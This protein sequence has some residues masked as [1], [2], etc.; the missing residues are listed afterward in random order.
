MSHIDGRRQRRLS[1]SKE[2]Q[3]RLGCTM[4]T[5]HGAKQG[6]R[7]TR[8]RLNRPVQAMRN[9]HCNGS[10][11]CECP[12]CDDD[13]LHTDYPHFPTHDG[14]T[15]GGYSPLGVACRRLRRQGEAHR[16]HGLIRSSLPG[17][18]VDLV[19]IDDTTGDRLEVQCWLPSMNLIV[20]WA[21]PRPVHGGATLVSPCG[22]NEQ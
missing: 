19:T 3:K 11:D 1:K 2:Y 17:T 12:G 5:G 8:H 14:C 15:C 13:A 6:R 7:R 20:W 4:V 21:L 10:L 16:I 18:P 22:V 9:F